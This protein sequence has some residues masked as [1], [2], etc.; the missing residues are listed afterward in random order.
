MA[1]ATANEK[2]KMLGTGEWKE[3]EEVEGVLEKPNADDDLGEQVDEKCCQ[4]DASE[5]AL[6]DAANELLKLAFADCDVAA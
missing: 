1:A 2:D 5:G 6:D 3:V 4:T